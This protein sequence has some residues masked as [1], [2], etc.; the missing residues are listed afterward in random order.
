LLVV[1][2]P[3]RLWCNLSMHAGPMRVAQSLNLATTE[4]RQNECSQKA[5]LISGQSP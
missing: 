3:R 2:A 5:L 4:L 1:G